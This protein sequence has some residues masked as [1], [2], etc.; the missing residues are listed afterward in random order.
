M[1]VEIPLVC[2]GNK[3]L[4]SSNVDVVGTGKGTNKKEDNVVKVKVEM[5]GVCGKISPENRCNLTG[6]DCF[7]K[8]KST[9]GKIKFDEDGDEEFI[10]MDEED[11]H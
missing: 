8:E 3:V 10:D 11:R 5:V 4:V 7:L 9:A 2:L 6:L 1:S